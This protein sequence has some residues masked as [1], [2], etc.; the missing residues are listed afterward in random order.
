MVC[1][2][3][4]KKTCY[5][6]YSKNQKLFGDHVVYT[7]LFM[8]TTIFHI[9]DNHFLERRLLRNQRDIGEFL[10]SFKGVGKK[11]GEDLTK[12][13]KE[14]IK[15]AAEAVSSG[16]SQD[17]VSNLLE[18]GNYVAECITALNPSKLDIKTTRS[19][20]RTH[21]KHV[22]KIAVIYMKGQFEKEVAAL[23]AYF[24]HMIE[25]ANLIFFALT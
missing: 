5:C 16:G 1:P 9:S 17:A 11:K 4:S 18:Q 10:G 24:E 19:A 21:N 15:L 14:H 2:K 23:D 3:T 25:V 20:F 13:L 6:A 7:T 22:L 12:A 8:K